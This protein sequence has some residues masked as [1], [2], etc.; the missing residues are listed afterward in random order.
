MQAAVE[1]GVRGAE[2]RACIFVVSIVFRGH[3]LTADMDR[4]RQLLSS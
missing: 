2:V 3:D 4:L 1:L